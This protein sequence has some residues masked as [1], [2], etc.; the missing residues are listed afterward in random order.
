MNNHHKVPKVAIV[1]MAFPGYSLKDELAENKLD[2]ALPYFDG[3]NIQLVRSSSVVTNTKAAEEIGIE[4]MEKKVDCIVALL[5]TFVPDYFI[6]GLLDHCNVPI[7]LYAVEREIDCISLVGAMLSNPTLYDLGKLYDLGAGELGDPQIMS[8]VLSFCRASMM[9]NV[10]KEM[11]VGYMGKNPEIMFSMQADEYGLKQTMGVTVVP[12]RDFEYSEWGNQVTDKEASRD[13]ANLKQNVGPVSVDEGD[14]IQASRA[15][16]AMTRL[17]RERKLDALSINCWTQLKSKIC[18]P[19]ARLNDIG[20]GA[21]CEGDLHS[22]I[23]M[24]LMYVLSGQGVL[25]GDFLRLIP[26]DNQIVFS[27]CGAGTLSMAERERDI[28]LH[29]SN[30]TQDGIG[31][32]FPVEK[33][34][35][36]TAVNLIGS[37]A[38][39]RVAA[40]HGQAKAGE[41]VYDGN[42]IRI[43]F[44]R[45]VH[46]VLGAAVNCGAGHHWNIIYGD[47]IEDF[48]YLCRF[49]KIDFNL[50]S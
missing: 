13:W 36:V 12:L 43:E 33:E 30:E 2:Q 22:T 44:E 35:D 50:L 9:R 3:E 15:Y 23:L 17:S 25:N 14:A 27:H 48:R 28:N 45:P 47:Y 34:G 39:Y 19:I 6:V 8:R 20:I 46:D 42:P 40:L 16:I 4:M 29:P 18:L 38:G 26:E 49:L 41:V 31:V 11:R 37:R 21:G 24:R 7:F 5:T 32:F 1:P 10:L